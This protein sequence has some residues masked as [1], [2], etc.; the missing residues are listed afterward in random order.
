MVRQAEDIIAPE[1]QENG[2]VF[3]FRVLHVEKDSEAHQAGLEPLFDFIVG[4]NGHQL[5]DS[6]RHEAQ[7]AETAPVDELKAHLAES[8]PITL[9]VWSM[10]GKVIRVVK[11]RAHPTEDGL[12]GLGLNV[13]WTALKV[14]DHVWHVLNITEGSPADHAGL[15]SN[16][17]YIVGAENGLLE[18]GGES[19]LARVASK[20]AS[21]EKHNGFEVYVY[22]SDTNA[23]RP[24]RITPRFDPTGHRLLGCSVGYGFLHRLPAI[25]TD[26]EGVS[27]PSDIVDTGDVATPT[28]PLSADAFI[29]AAAPTMPQPSPPQFAP[30]PTAPA[31]RPAHRNRHHGPEQDLS[32]YFEE[33]TAKS[34]EI[35]GHKTSVPAAAPPPPPPA[36]KLA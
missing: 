29:P 34:H 9:S 35:D 6:R 32:A 18:Q 14:G 22:N 25:S 10:K 27:S 7:A 17:D 31:S 8:N 33:Q 16:S 21:D 28:D 4:V 1:L 30:P 12:F 13:Q 11:L 20:Y 24:V 36:A 26:T 5:S 3:G 15:I 19:L 2:P 23:T